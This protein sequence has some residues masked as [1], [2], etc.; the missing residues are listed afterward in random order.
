MFLLRY[1]I[2]EREKFYIFFIFISNLQL[3]VKFIDLF[4]KKVKIN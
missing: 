2:L 1:I 3:I 4:L